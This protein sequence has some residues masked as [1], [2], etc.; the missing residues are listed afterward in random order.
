MENNWEGKCE[1]TCWTRGTWSRWT[2]LR[3][4]GTDIDNKLRRKL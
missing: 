1:G 4:K 3:S 2:D